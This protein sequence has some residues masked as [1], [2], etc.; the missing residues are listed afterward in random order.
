MGTSVG[1]DVPIMAGA[2]CGGNVDDPTVSAMTHRVAV[3]VF[4]DFQI[5]DATGPI[6]ALEVAGRGGR[7]LYEA[8]VLAAEPARAVSSAGVPLGAAPLEAARPF[9]TLIVS[10]GQ[11]TRGAISCARTVDFVR[12][13]H[14]R[15]ARIASVCS[16]AF[17][18]AQAGLLEG[19]AVT[20]HW[21]AAD[22]FRRLYPHL[23]L[24]PD[25]IYTRKG[26]VW[27]SA[28]ITAGIDLTLALIAEDHGEAAARRAAQMLVVFHR[29]PGGQSQFSDALDLQ[30]RADRF[31]EVIAWARER[32][33]QPLTVEQL[34]ERACLSPRQFARAFAAATGVTPAKAVERLRVEAARALVEESAVSVERIAER[35]GFGE[36]ERMRRAFIRAFGHPPQ[37]LRR[38]ARA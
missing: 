18:L 23:K 27:T 20:T 16:G 4:P 24:E 37:A 11:G 28:G 8:Q 15:G 30:A 36:P 35:A 33:D 9:D 5:L 10:G 6:A 21:S 38:A 19:M 7:P 14:A 1:L 3:L 31:S 29:R 32:L 17:L 22:E 12:R 2:A 25:R 13:A 34:A 26:R